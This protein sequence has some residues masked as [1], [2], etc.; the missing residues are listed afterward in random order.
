[1]L[2]LCIEKVHDK[3]ANECIFYQETLRCEGIGKDLGL[4][5]TRRNL[6]KSQALKFGVRAS[7]LGCRQTLLKHVWCVMFSCEATPK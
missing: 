7:V 2:S 1:M 5:F 6:L 4:T 3:R